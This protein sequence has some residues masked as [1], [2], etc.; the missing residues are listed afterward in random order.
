MLTGVLVAGSHLALDR[1]WL[2]YLRTG[3]RDMPMLR[4]VRRETFNMALDGLF[5]GAIARCGSQAARS[6]PPSEFPLK[7]VFL[8]LGEASDDAARLLGDP[9]RSAWQR[10]EGHWATGASLP[11]RCF[12]L[13]PAD[14]RYAGRGR[15]VMAKDVT[16]SLL[17]KMQFRVGTGSG[18]S[19]VIDASPD[20]GGAEAGPRPMGIQG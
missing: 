1:M 5:Y 8:Y 14:P 19:L 7:R 6:G 20:V 4:R 11:C 9:C 18:H 3:S 10:A 2:P 15:D 16:V 17:E 13:S 12:S